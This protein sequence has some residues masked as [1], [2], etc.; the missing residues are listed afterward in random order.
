MR[1]RSFAGPLLLVIIGGLFLFRNLHPEAPIFDLIAEYWPFALIAW[2]LLRLIEVVVSRQVR[3]PGLTGGE[4]AL[5]V[6]ISMAGLGLFEVHRRG[7]RFT[8]EIFGEQFDY[9]VEAHAPAAGMKRIIFENARGNIRVTGGDTQDVTINGHKLIR[10]YTREEADRTNGNTPLEI[11]PEGD[12]LVVHVNQE[13]APEHQRVSDDLEVTVPR[14]VT[15]ERRGP[16][17]DFDASDVDGD[18]EVSVLRGDVR[19][20]RIAG[21]AR[22]QVGR[23]DLIR[24]SDVRGSID[25]DGRGSDVELQNI[26]GQVSIKGGYVGTLDFKN[27]AKPL[28][29]QGA[30]NTELSVVAVPGSISMD[31]GEVTAK[32]L[33]GPVRLVTQ[34]RDI[35]LEDF[36]QSLELETQRGDVELLPGRAPLPRIEAR[37]RI[38]KI[39]LALPDKAAFQL[40]ATAQRGDVINDFG[41]EIQKEMQGRVATLRGAVG[42]G[43]MIRITTERGSVSVRKQ[44]ATPAETKNLKDTEV[45]L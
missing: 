35:K 30:R 12:R 37:S 23:S 4:V 17:G 38:G 24:A 2:G 7:I 44:G 13:R 29:F 14:G 1:R 3:Y 32:N 41:P 27:L 21:S 26:G 39:D 20:A 15:I 16:A 8:P 36:T 18:I 40:Q 33:V 31:L 22:L 5:I 45:K 25:L 11:A 43:P 9:P 10:A 34:S 28:D 6:L 19:L 42:E